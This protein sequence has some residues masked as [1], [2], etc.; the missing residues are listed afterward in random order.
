[1]RA[2]RRIEILASLPRNAQGKI[3]RRE[4]AGMIDPRKVGE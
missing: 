1:V 4:I 3:V 2:P